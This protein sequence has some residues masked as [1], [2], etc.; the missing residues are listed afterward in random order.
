M[1]V[2]LIKTKSLFEH[3]SYISYDVVRISPMLYL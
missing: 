1:E 2:L 3:T